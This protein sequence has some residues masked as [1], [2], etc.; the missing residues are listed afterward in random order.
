MLNDLQGKIE[1]KLGHPHKV[2]HT[3]A[4]HPSSLEIISAADNTV[5]LWNIKQ[6][7]ASKSLL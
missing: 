7:D 2:V 5:Y 3:L 4:V 1:A 6:E